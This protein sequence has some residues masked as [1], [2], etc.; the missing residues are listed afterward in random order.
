LGR[1]NARRRDRLGPLLAFAVAAF[2]LAVL[3]PAAQ[4]AL[5]EYPP[6]WHGWFGASA[7]PLSPPRVRVGDRVPDFTLQDLAGRP[8]RMSALRARVPVVVE[9]GS[10]T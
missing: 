5:S 4:Q 3:F 9:F 8:V 1:R 2:P 10:F 6:P 7:A